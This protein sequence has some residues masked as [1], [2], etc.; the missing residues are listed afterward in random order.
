MT[1]PRSELNPTTK[2]L[3][4]HAFVGVLIAALWSLS[5]LIITFTITTAIDMLQ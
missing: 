1:R 4:E 5:L 2:R 3:L